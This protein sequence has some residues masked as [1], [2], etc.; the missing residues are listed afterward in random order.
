MKYFFDTEFIEDGEIIDLISIGI[1]AEDGRELYYISN[2]FNPCRASQWVIDNVLS[3]LPAAPSGSNIFAIIDFPNLLNKGKLWCPQRINL[4][5]PSISPKQKSDALLW[6]DKK[7]IANKI[8]DFIGDDK[9]EFWAAWSSY[10][11]V[12]FCQ[13]FGTMMD[14]PEGYP[15]Y[16][17]DTIQWLNNLKLPR[18]Y[19]PPSPSEEHNALADAKWVRDS[20]Y[21][22]ED[23]INYKKEY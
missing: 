22:I 7:Y 8:K 3:K 1:V 6:Q 14:L 16:C 11:W 4:S 20:Y 10:D 13:L 15:Y 2:E 18:E 9:P 19:L 5:D 12:V 23:Y 21:K 17:N